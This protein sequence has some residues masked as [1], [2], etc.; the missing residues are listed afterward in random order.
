MVTGNKVSGDYPLETQKCLQLIVEKINFD[1]TLYLD[2]QHV[3]RVLRAGL[4]SG[5]QEAAELAQSVQDQLL[6]L[7]RFE[8]RELDG[9]VAG[10]HVESE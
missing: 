3:K 1:Q 8:F 7:G 9:L 2:E 4:H 5:V 10:T 6:R